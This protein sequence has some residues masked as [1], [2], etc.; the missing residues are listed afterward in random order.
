MIQKYKNSLILINY[1][2]FSHSSLSIQHSS[3]KNLSLKLN[4]K[5]FRLRQIKQ[6]LSTQRIEI[7]VKQSDKSIFQVNTASRQRAWQAITK[8][9]KHLGLEVGIEVVI[10]NFLH[11]HQIVE[12][13]PRSLTVKTP[14]Y[15]FLQLMVEAIVELLTYLLVHVGMAQVVNIQKPFISRTDHPLYSGT[16]LGLFEVSQVKLR[17]HAHHR[18]VREVVVEQGFCV[19]YGLHGYIIRRLQL[20]KYFFATNIIIISINSTQKSISL[21]LFRCF[22]I[23]PQRVFLSF[24]SISLYHHRKYIRILR[25]FVLFAI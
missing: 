17:L 10:L 21:S 5:L 25:L 14:C 9:G 6:L 12:K 1:F 19:D 7:K 22:I 16:D 8:D 18:D 13:L 24:L 11:R 20:F 23:V 2:L 3:F 15:G 4:P